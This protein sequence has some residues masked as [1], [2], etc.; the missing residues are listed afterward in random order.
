MSYRYK[1]VPLKDDKPVKGLCITTVM[2]N[3]N[4]AA[5]NVAQLDMQKYKQHGI[6]VDHI[7]VYKHVNGNFKLIATVYE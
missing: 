7:E 6:E 4:V 2:R 1:L 5:V 3:Y